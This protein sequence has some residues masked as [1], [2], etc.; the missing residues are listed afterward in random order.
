MIIRVVRMHIIPEKV[1]EFL[2]IFVRTK[3]AIRNVEGCLH[4]ELLRDGEH[5][6]NFTT[7]SHW[8]NI[9]DLESY[10]NSELFKNVWTRVKPLFGKPAEAF[11]LHSFIEV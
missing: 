7:L 2:E 11:S 10:R 6:N 4:L 1:D 5:N 9:S 3:D 8:N